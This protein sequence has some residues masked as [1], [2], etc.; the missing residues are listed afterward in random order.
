MLKSLTPVEASVDVSTAGLDSCSG[1]PVTIATVGETIGGA[2]ETETCAGRWVL[3]GVT[4]KGGV[5]SD[6]VCWEVA[7]G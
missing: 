6:D 3:G 2:D 5:E 4:L 1:V 7:K